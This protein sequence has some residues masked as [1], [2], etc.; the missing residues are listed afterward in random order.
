MSV[1][2]N[3][4]KDKLILEPT[5]LTSPDVVVREVA[6]Q[7]DE[8]TSGTVQAIVQSYDG[9]IESYT[10]KETSLSSILSATQLS[11]LVDHD[12]QENLGAL[13]FKRSNYELYLTTKN[14]P[15]YKYRILFFGFGIGGYPVKVV[16]E[17]SIASAINKEG[18]AFVVKD[19]PELES[20]MKKILSSSKTIDIIQELINASKLAQVANDKE[21][22]GVALG[23]ERED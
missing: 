19:R 7:I 18:Y 14:L 10:T 11:A 12:V 21:E 22:S 3:G 23:D 6:D 17:K 13:G 15:H 4:L 1:D 5:D 8:I 2:L 9:R 16:V 20:L